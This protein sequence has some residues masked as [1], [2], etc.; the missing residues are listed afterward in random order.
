MFSVAVVVRTRLSPACPHLLF[1]GATLPHQGGAGSREVPL[2]NKP[3]EAV[4]GP[5]TAHPS[6][7][8]ELYHETRLPSNT[9]HS[10]TIA[11][12]HGLEWDQIHLTVRVRCA[13]LGGR[14][15][16]GSKDHAARNRTTLED[17][18]QARAT[19]VGGAAGRRRL[20]EHKGTLVQAASGGA[21]CTGRHAGRIPDCYTLSYPDSHAYAFFH[22][23]CDI[24][25][26][27]DGHRHSHAYPHTY[28]HA[29]GY[30]DCD[31]N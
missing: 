11:S 2:G 4:R 5:A 12:G 25:R 3:P 19:A 9:D 21:A 23:Y 29:H 27:F 24:N 31:A 1:R 18:D 8:L 20:L 30:H 10:G 13:I 15:K 16:R 28:T 22:A 26:C 17:L 7:H 14:R 6:A